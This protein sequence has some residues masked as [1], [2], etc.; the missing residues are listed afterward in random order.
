MKS[1]SY[2]YYQYVHKRIYTHNAPRHTHTARRSYPRTPNPLN[3]KNI[4]YAHPRIPWA[5]IHGD[6]HHTYRIRC[7][8]E[9]GYVQKVASSDLER[10]CTSLKQGG[11]GMVLERSNK[12]YQGGACIEF[13]LTLVASR[14]P[15]GRPVSFPSVVGNA[16]H[17]TETHHAA[18]KTLN[19]SKKHTWYSIGAKKSEHY[20]TMG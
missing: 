3:P 10:A 15:A 11:V 7:R 18:C 2:L 6:L 14:R 8:F 16:R 20:C 9:A 4:L 12:R 5:A 1:G 17:A 13:L 19:R